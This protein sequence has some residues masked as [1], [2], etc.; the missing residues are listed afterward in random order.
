MDEGLREKYAE[1]EVVRNVLK[2]I[3]PGTF[4]DMLIKKEGLTLAELKRF[5]RSH[6][7]DKSSFN[8]G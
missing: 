5:L 7:R 3:K 6:L 4:R 1:S 8:R 2:V